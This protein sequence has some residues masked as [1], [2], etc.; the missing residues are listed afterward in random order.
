MKRANEER[1][2]DEHTQKT[3]K[4]QKAAKKKNKTKNVLEPQ[5]TTNEQTTNKQ[6]RLQEKNC[7]RFFTLYS[8]L[9]FLSPSSTIG[10]FF[11]PFHPSKEHLDEQKRR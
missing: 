4:Q 7:L 10:L 3:I 6:A 2:R 11:F 5:R 9:V 8:P 1:R